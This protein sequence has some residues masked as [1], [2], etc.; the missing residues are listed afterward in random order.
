[1]PLPAE[2]LDEPAQLSLSYVKPTYANGFYVVRISPSAPI[3]QDPE[4]IVPSELARGHEWEATI[5]ALDAR[6]CVKAKAKFA[7][8]TQLQRAE[9][10]VKDTASAGYE[11]FKEWMWPSRQRSST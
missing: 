11:A 7:P 3:D 9:A 8:S 2:H 4:H 5:E 1:M 6:I 10:Q